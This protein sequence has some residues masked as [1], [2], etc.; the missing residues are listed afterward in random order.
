MKK[1]SGGKLPSRQLP[2]SSSAESASDKPALSSNNS[3][4]TDKGQDGNIPGVTAPQVYLAGV[5]NRP[6]PRQKTRRH[7]P[8][9]QSGRRTIRPQ[10]SQTAVTAVSAT[11]QS[12]FWWDGKI[13]ASRL[14]LNASVNPG[15]HQR[16]IL[17]PRDKK[18][19]AANLKELPPLTRKVQRA[20]TLANLA[21]QKTCHIAKVMSI[22]RRKAVRLLGLSSVAC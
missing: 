4:S 19:A 9:C 2:L 3:P 12:P 7:Y 1:G 21:V 13:V 18:R 11:D 16:L 17:R 15:N 5:L 6:T 22:W 10:G 8:R 14:V 20:L